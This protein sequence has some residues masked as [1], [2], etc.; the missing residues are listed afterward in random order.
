MTQPSLDRCGIEQVGRIFALDE[1]L[2]ALFDQIPMQVEVGEVLRVLGDLAGQALELQTPHFRIEIEGHGK[3]RR[4]A[5]VAPRRQEPHEPGV[6]ELLM[7]EGVGERRM[8]LRRVIGERN[9]IHGCSYGQKMH[10]VPDQ[11][12][13]ALERLPR[14][15]NADREVA[16]PAEPVQEYLIRREQRRIRRPP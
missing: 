16:L 10:A 3:E 4:S 14:R 1:I 5:R 11:G 12:R 8:N 6:G 15:R 7:V 9:L 2:V 13:L